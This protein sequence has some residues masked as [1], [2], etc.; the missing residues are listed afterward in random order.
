[1]AYAH[2]FYEGYFKDNPTRVKRT[3][4]TVYLASDDWLMF[5]RTQNEYVTLQDD[6]KIR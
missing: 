5:R 6:I 3:Q 2:E 4:R 1:M